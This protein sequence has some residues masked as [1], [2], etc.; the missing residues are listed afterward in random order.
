MSPHCLAVPGSSKARTAPGSQAAYYG[1]GALAVDVAQR[2]ALN[3]RQA[4]G[5]AAA[6]QQTWTNFL[7]ALAEACLPVLGHIVYYAISLAVATAVTVASLE[8]QST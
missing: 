3:Y 8:T 6:N 7:G 4:H 2:H 5:S 1:T